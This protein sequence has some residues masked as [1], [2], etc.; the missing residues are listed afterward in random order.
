MV[1][2]PMG[3]SLP[4]YYHHNGDRQRRE[5]DNGTADQ[6]R[7][8]RHTATFAAARLPGAEQDNAGGTRLRSFPVGEIID[9]AN[10]YQAKPDSAKRPNQQR[11]DGHGAPPEGHDGHWDQDPEERNNQDRRDE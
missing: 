6:P 8:R 10:A 5:C 1:A 7:G 9:H 11:F 4:A 3:A 2:L